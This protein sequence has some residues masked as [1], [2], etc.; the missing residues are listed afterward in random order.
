MSLKRFKR[1]SLLD[2]QERL[3]AKKPKE[4]IKV[5]PKKKGKK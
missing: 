5:E 2:K 4:E 1:A 3:A